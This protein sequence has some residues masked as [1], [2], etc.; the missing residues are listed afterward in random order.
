MLFSIIV[1]VYNCEKYLEQCIQ[2][3][4]NQD[5]QDYEIVLINDA[6]EDASQHICNK[7][8][9]NEKVTVIH[10]KQ[11]RGLSYSR[12]IGIACA[13]GKYII[14]L[15]SDDNWNPNILFGL[16]KKVIHSDITIFGYIEKNAAK[17]T[18]IVCNCSKYQC[19]D[20]ITGKS[21][22]KKALEAE[23]NY[24]WYAWRYAISKDLMNE[25][26]FQFPEK[27]CYEDVY[28]IYSLLLNSKRVHFYPVNVVN[29]TTGRDGSITGTVSLKIELNKLYVALHNIRQVI[30]SKYDL[31]LKKLLC[32]NFS[33][34][35]Y[36]C[37][38]ECFYLTNKKE[39]NI[40]MHKLEN[41]R[42]MSHYTTTNSYM[43]IAIL[44][45]LFGRGGVRPIGKMLFLRSKIKSFIY[46]K[47]GKEKSRNRGRKCILKTVK[48]Y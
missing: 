11:N 26:S 46:K 19:K 2:S 27:L 5:F 1:P 16:A 30:K 10:N 41:L 42:W 13:K 44:L 28:S 24:A 31:N 35:Y 25:I 7:Y 48:D 18:N 40:L 8:K 45:E 22:L 43:P 23:N 34:L 17:E 29:Y 14:F 21:F 4:L 37:L 39:Q 12:N 9:K 6:S 32:N 33:F 3:V 47:N 36:S 20:G 15:D 38:I